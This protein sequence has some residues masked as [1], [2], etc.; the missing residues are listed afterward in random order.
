MQFLRQETFFSIC[1]K[2]SLVVYLPCNEIDK[3][4]QLLRDWQDK[5]SKASDVGFQGLAS[6]SHKLLCQLDTNIAIIIFHLVD[7]LKGL[8]IGTLVG[9]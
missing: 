6:N 1:K 4:K 2:Y 9:A 8:V 7:T 3:E 5:G